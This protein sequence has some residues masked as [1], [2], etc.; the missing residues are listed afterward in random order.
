MPPRFKSEPSPRAHNNSRHIA[1]LPQPLPAAIRPQH[2]THR[3]ALQPRPH[4]HPALRWLNIDIPGPRPCAPRQPLLEWHPSSTVSSSSPPQHPPCRRSPPHSAPRSPPTR[5][6]S[7]SG[8]ASTAAARTAHGMRGLLLRSRRAGGGTARPAPGTTSRPLLPRRPHPLLQPRHPAPAAGAHQ[9][10]PSRPDACSRV[11]APPRPSHT[12]MTRRRTPAQSATLRT[13]VRLGMIHR[14][15]A[16]YSFPLFTLYIP[17]RTSNAT[18]LSYA[19]MSL[20]H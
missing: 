19:H 2:R 17:A 18:Y 13:R 7:C 11:A 14:I 5:H 8:Y 20:H 9:A 15:D 6:H 10:T 1:M 12:P 4:C 16:T 3:S